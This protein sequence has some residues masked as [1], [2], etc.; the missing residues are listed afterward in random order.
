MLNWLKNIKT[1][2]KVKC[3]VMSCF[4]KR[5]IFL[6][7]EK[8]GA[9]FEKIIHFLISY[10][11]WNSARQTILILHKHLFTQRKL[12]QLTYNGTYFYLLTSN[13][14]KEAILL[15]NLRPVYKILY[16]A[17]P[18]ISLY[19][20]SPILLYLQVFLLSSLPLYSYW[21]TQVSVQS[22]FLKEWCTQA[23]LYVLNSHL[24]PNN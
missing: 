4:L 8:Q 7:H 14:K 11:L 2:L 1:T 17:S 20:L 3:N 10:I 15:L 16:S 19:K 5:N 22:N 24:F 18:V 21:H 12:T 13:S 6:V 23:C 9:C